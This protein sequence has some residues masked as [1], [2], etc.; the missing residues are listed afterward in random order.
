MFISHFFTELGDGPFSL[1]SAGYN[2]TMFGV[3]RT[4]SLVFPLV[5]ERP[6]QMPAP[7]L[8]FNFMITAGLQKD[9]TSREHLHSCKKKTLALFGFGGH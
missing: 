5:R 9:R 6:G 4:S 8:L 3:N 7:G 1:V 2:G